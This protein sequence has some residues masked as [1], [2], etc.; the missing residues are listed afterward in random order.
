MTY[1]T[2]C[3]NF[4]KV[5]IVVQSLVGH[6]L[7]KNIVSFSAPIL[8]VDIYLSKKR[9]TDFSAVSYF[10]VSFKLTIVTTSKQSSCAFNCAIIKSHY[11][12]LFSVKHFFLSIQKYVI[13]FVTDISVVKFRGALLYLRRSVRRLRKCIGAEESIQKTFKDLYQ[14]DELIYHKYYQLCTYFVLKL[15]INQ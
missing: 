9:I 3:I 8:D 11:L 10:S 14:Y 5:M 13:T 12:K 15:F 6:R 7:V 2:P 4:T 1:T